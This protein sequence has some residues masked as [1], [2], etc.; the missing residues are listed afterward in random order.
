MELYF[1][2]DGR[3]IALLVLQGGEVQEVIVGEPSPDAIKTTFAL[4]KEAGRV[5]V[6]TREV[7]TRLFFKFPGRLTD[8]AV[9]EVR[10][11]TLE[12]GAVY[13]LSLTERAYD[14]VLD[15]LGVVE[16]EKLKTA[17]QGD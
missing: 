6:P 13:G 14:F 10:Q 17:V 7:L 3:E 12:V 9:A 4:L 1:D 2:F 8:E 5:F 15:R 16:A 11:K